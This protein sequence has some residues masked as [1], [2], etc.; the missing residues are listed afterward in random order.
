MLFTG[1]LTEGVNAA[2]DGSVSAVKLVVKLVAVSVDNA[3]NGNA[4]ICVSDELNGSAVCCGHSCVEVGVV[5]TVNVSYLKTCGEVVVSVPG[6]L[7]SVCKS[8][9][10]I[11]AEDIVEN[12]GVCLAVDLCGDV[13]KANRL[14][15]G[16]SQALG[17]VESD[18]GSVG[19][20]CGEG[21][22]V[23]YTNVLTVDVCCKRTVGR[24]TG[25][26]V[27]CANSVD[28]S[29]VDPLA[30]IELYGAKRVAN[31]ADANV[32]KVAGNSVEEEVGPAVLRRILAGSVVTAEVDVASELRKHLTLGSDIVLKHDVRG[33]DKLGLVQV[34]NAEVG[35]TNEL[36]HVVSV[37]YEVVVV[38][39]EGVTL[40][41]VT[42]TDY[43]VEVISIVND[44]TSGLTISVAV[45]VGFGVEVS[46]IEVS[47]C[48]E[49]EVVTNLGSFL[50]EYKTYVG[51]GAPRVS[52]AALVGLPLLTGSSVAADLGVSGS[53]GENDSAFTIGET[54]NA[55]NKT[56]VPNNVRAEL[57]IKNTVVEGSLSC[58]SHDT[59]VTTG[60][61]SACLGSNLTATD[62]GV[63]CV[64]DGH[65]ISLSLGEGGTDEYSPG[66]EEGG[67]V[68]VKLTLTAVTGHINELTC[69]VVKGGYDQL[70]VTSGEYGVRLSGGRSVEDEHSGGNVCG[71]VLSCNV[72]SDR[73][74]VNVN[75][76]VAAELEGA[77][78]SV[79]NEVTS[80]KGYLCIA[81]YEEEAVVNGSVSG[82]VNV[83]EVSGT[84]GKGEEGGLGF[85]IRTGKNVDVLKGKTS[86]VLTCIDLTDRLTT[87]VNDSTVLEGDVSLLIFSLIYFDKR[88]G[89]F[90][91]IDGVTVKVDHD[92]LSGCAVACGELNVLQELYSLAGINCQHG[93]SIGGILLAGFYDHSFIS[94]LCRDCKNESC[95]K[96]SNDKNYAE[97]FAKVFHFEFSPFEKI[98][99]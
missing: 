51:T 14:V 7:G 58:T 10:G 59:V 16:K 25:S 60:T 50:S 42:T 29:Y 55:V 21:S 68:E 37:V 74:V 19:S 63:L 8:L 5:L 66:C 4:S 52:G 93:I 44:L 65:L 88:G 73:G 40:S 95:A 78:G 76:G 53:G 15:A 17:V 61:G 18:L 62:V 70:R 75:G 46:G 20:K 48:L 99:N 27:N 69:L 92:S 71:S 24:G 56:G 41:N 90:R 23:A 85:T 28:L 1:V 72:N 9:G 45:I 3:G 34:G 38:V 31:V 79:R 11:L 39:G 77:V 94:S 12:A 97:D 86:S 96:K 6:V 80:L 26:S 84:A 91:H 33:V 43:E 36:G 32:V 22:G 57:R 98:S 67:V 83:V 35:V 81:S 49:E 30:G 47:T 2:V 89:G 13:V 82:P 64:D 87:V 54:G